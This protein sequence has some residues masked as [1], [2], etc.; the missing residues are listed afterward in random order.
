M[1]HKAD[2]QRSQCRSSPAVTALLATITS[3]QLYQLLPPRLALLLVKLL[4]VSVR[5]LNMSAHTLKA[6]AVPRIFAPTPKSL[7]CR[8]QQG[9]LH[10]LAGL[11]NKNRTLVLGCVVGLIC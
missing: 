11:T 10:A 9:L 2:G 8:K 3:W 5:V 1:N 7:Q 4:Q 6:H